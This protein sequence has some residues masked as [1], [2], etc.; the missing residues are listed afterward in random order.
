MAHTLDLDKAY[1]T[2]QFYGEEHGIRNLWEALDHMGKHSDL[3]TKEEREAHKALSD[4]LYVGLIN[5][6][7]KAVIINE[8]DGYTD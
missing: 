4:D 2:V 5:R 8:D 1:V 7:S 6:S 3:L